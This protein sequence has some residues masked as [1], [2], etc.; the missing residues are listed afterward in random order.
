MSLSSLPEQI[1]DRLRRD[2]LRG[3]LAPGAAIKERDKAAHEGVSRTPMR[4]AIRILAREG[5]VVLRPARSPIVA[6]P[7]IKE[8]T[9][10]LVV[11][12]ELEV[13]SVR[14]ACLHAPDD[15]V[16]RIKSLNEQFGLEY[17]HRDMLDLF[18]MDMAFH[19]AI[20]AASGNAALE[21]TH[22][23]YLARLWRARYLSARERRSRDRVLTQHG[24]IVDAL[25]ARDPDR[26]AIATGAHLRDL[27]TNITAVMAGE[28][29]SANETETRTRDTA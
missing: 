26:A 16:E 15:A 17:A 14:L 3:D 28:D 9:D 12:C 8:V 23:A 13:L 6:D 5:L 25:V 29:N 4:E 7:S 18:E 11:M 19:R 1:A 20:A 2:I 21:R 22:G 27:V 10:E 24:A